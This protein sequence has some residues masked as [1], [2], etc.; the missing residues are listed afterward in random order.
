[1]SATAIMDDIDQIIQNAQQTAEK[2]AE[3]AEDFAGDAI[4][5]GMGWA[6]TGAASH[7]DYATAFTM[8][9]FLG[10]EDLSVMFKTALGD[11][12]GAMD[13]DLQDKLQSWV[14]VY[15]PT[16]D[17]CVRTSSD[18]WICE[19][20]DGTRQ[21][22]LPTHVVDAMWQKGRE[23]VINDSMLAYE[24]TISKYAAMGF[25]LPSGVLE[26]QLAVVTRGAQEKMSEHNVAITIE[27]AKISVDVT[28]FAV[29]QAV[30]L[31]LQIV[32]AMSDMIKAWVSVYGAAVD[33]AKATVEAKSKMWNSSADYIRARAAWGDI[34][35]KP[36]IAEAEVHAKLA[37][38]DVQAFGERMKAAVQ[39]NVAAAE[40]MAKIAA[41]ALAA[42]QT[43]A[44]ETYQ[45]SMSG[46]ATN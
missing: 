33:A 31:R 29:E 16:Y 25:S 30:K 35:I 6:S 7:V 15:F 3:K 40:A 9:D 11:Y 22:G 36:S 4:T 5:A 27:A 37:I 45:V 32:V 41:A 44:A 38:A 10:G 19:T 39:G 8:P 2:Y 18:A 28:K 46:K 43:K 13:A 1:M 17:P 14:N 26:A 24:Q 12:W 42:Q 21:I 23:R 20:I 34:E